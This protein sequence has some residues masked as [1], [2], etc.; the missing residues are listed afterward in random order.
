MPSRGRPLSPR[1]YKRYHRSSGGF[2]LTGSPVGSGEER[3]TLP[4]AEPVGLLTGRYAP[5]PSLSASP[6]IQFTLEAPRWA[7]LQPLRGRGL[8]TPIFVGA[9]ARIKRSGAFTS[10]WSRLIF[11]SCALTRLRSRSRL[12]F[13][14]RAS[15]FDPLCV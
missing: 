7:Y 6:V 10:R 5:K 11:P 13:N 8:S 15:G 4:K 3:G 14:R 2:H 12:P 9:F 1:C